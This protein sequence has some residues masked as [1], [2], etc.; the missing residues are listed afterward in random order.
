M[1]FVPSQNGRSHCEEEFTAA[2][3]IAHGVDVL[4][5]FLIAGSRADC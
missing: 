5:E 1:I 4:T 2:D 3:Q